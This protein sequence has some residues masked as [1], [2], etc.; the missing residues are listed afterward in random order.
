MIRIIFKHSKSAICADAN[1]NIL[2]ASAV[3]NSVTE[4]C[5]VSV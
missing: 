4:N 3:T 5:I 1:V 2:E